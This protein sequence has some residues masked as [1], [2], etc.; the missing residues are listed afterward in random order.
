[1]SPEPVLAATSLLAPVP[2]DW[3]PAS[4][5]PVLPGLPVAVGSDPPLGACEAS[6][7]PDPVLAGALAGE[8]DSVGVVCVDGAS[9]TAQ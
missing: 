9:C 5:V 6:P 3:L 2:E 7:P 8:G 4:V 1:V